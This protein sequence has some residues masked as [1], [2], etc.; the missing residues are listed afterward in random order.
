MHTIYSLHFRPDHAASD[1]GNGLK[2][3]SDG[4]TWNRHRVNRTQMNPECSRSAPRPSLCD[5]GC[6]DCLQPCA[7]YHP[8][9]PFFLRLLIFLPFFSYHGAHKDAKETGSISA[10]LGAYRII[11]EIRA[12][13]DVGYS[14]SLVPWCLKDMYFW[15]TAFAIF[16]YLSCPSCPSPW[17]ELLIHRWESKSDAISS[18][19]AVL[20]T[21]QSSWIHFSF[22]LFHAF[23][24][25]PFCICGDHDTRSVPTFLVCKSL[26]NK[27]SSAV[28]SEG[29]SLALIYPVWRVWQ[30]PK[31]LSMRS[32]ILMPTRSSFL[33]SSSILLCLGKCPWSIVSA[34]HHSS[35]NSL[36]L[37]FSCSPPLP[38][39]SIGPFTRR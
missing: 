30:D 14:P 32:L 24:I 20:N 7:L 29:R 19:N 9:P 28:C 33:V 34:L 22:F 27:V 37:W 3:L 5:W 23:S 25:F 12:Q 11:M 38:R 16:L 1:E 10:L 39:G 15:P 17:R 6:V 21:R 35:P 26:G 13:W 4:V 2:Q 18:L 36:C 8:P 31:F